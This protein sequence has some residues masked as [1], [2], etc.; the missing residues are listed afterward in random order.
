[1][2]L[3]HETENNNSWYDSTALWPETTSIF[4]RITPGDVDYFTFYAAPSTNTYQ[5]VTF[6]AYVYDYAGDGSLDTMLALFDENAQF[7][8]YNDDYNGRNPYL[9]GSIPQS[10]GGMLDLAVTGYLDYDFDGSGHE[11]DGYYMLD[12]YFRIEARNPTSKYTHHLSGSNYNEVIMGSAGYDII[13]A[14][15]GNDHIWSEGSSDQCYGGPG[16]DHIADFGW[17]AD[18]L[19]GEDGNDYIYG[20]GGGDKVD[21]G[22]GNDT[23]RGDSGHD[24]MYGGTGSDRLYGGTGTDT[25]SGGSGEDMFAY[26]FVDSSRDQ[27][28]DFNN[29]VGGDK[30]DLSEIDAI[31]GGWDDAFVFRGQ[32][33]FSGAG[34]VRVW[35]EEYFPGRYTGRT[36]V[37]VNVDSNLQPDFTI[38]VDDGGYTS[39]TWNLDHFIL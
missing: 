1:M 9:T 30:I 25:L 34:Q 27:I 22:R 31:S 6:S 21:G 38:V 3:V 13:H 5:S 26:D 18:F 28:T 37:Q 12:I 24:R 32:R 11:Q 17:E 19:Y 10:T 36:L 8:E 35:E 39:S 4:G 23:L 14:L 16:D 2:T 7:V 33:W 29:R 15:A 20:G